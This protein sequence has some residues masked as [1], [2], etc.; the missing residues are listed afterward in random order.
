MGT[1]S[2]ALFGDSGGGARRFVKKG[3]IRADG[4]LN[5]KKNLLLKVI[6]AVTKSP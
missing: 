6:V 4:Q 3:S 1:G 5:L 2:W